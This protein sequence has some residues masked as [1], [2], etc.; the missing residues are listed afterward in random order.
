MKR[1]AFAVQSLFQSFSKHLGSI[2]LFFLFP[3]LL[4]FLKWVPWCG[5]PL[6]QKWFSFE[7]MPPNLLFHVERLLFMPLAAIIVILFR[8]TLGLRVL[9]PTR[10]ILIAFAYA[11]IG[12]QQGTLFFLMALS[13][14]AMAR[15]K[16]KSSGIP[17]FARIGMA[18]T[19]ISLLILIS[20]RIGIATHDANFLSLSFL[21]VIMLTFAA[22]GF[23]KTLSKEGLGSAAW[24]ALMTIL[25]ATCIWWVFQIQPLGAFFVTHPELLLTQIGIMI[26][27][28]KH[29]DFRLLQRFNPI[30]HK[31]KKT[32]KSAKANQIKLA[33]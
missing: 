12:I 33:A 19:L 29:L 2:G 3:G 31:P 9:G 23:A 26:L 16:M 6:L 11:A 32:K 4:L 7:E 27:I 25:A 1:I 8:I 20:I 22:E 15:P 13:I 28:S 18:L 30:P 14:I 24:R 21:P 5:A 17:Y 10:P